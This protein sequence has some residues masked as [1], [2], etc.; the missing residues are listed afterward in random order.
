[1]TTNGA[2]KLFIGGSSDK[3]RST[4]YLGDDPASPKAAL[5]EPPLNVQ[6]NTGV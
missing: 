5:P 3:V 4:G 6:T 1:L 2:A